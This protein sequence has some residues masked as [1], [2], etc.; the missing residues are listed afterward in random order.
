MWPTE[1]ARRIG[2]PLALLARCGLTRGIAL[3][4]RETLTLWETLTLGELT[5]DASAGPTEA[6]GPPRGRWL[7]AGRVLATV[8]SAAPLLLCHV[9]KPN[10]RQVSSDC[11]GSKRPGDTRLW[12]AKPVPDIITSNRVPDRRIHRARRVAVSTLTR[13]IL[14]PIVAALV[15]AGLILGPGTQSARADGTAADFTATA[16]LGLDGI[17]TVRQDITFSTVPAEVQQTFE[18]KQDVL[19][20]RRYV[21]DVSGFRATVD[22][23]PVEPTVEVS[24]GRLTTVRFPTNGSKQVSLEYTV[25][26]AVMST[27]EG[28]ALVWPLLQ[29]F[30]STVS[31][32]TGTVAIPVPFAFVECNAGSPSS[33]VPCTYAAAGTGDARQP[34][35]RDGPRGPGEFVQVRIGFPPGAIAAN[36]HIEQVWT[37]A[38]AFSAKPLPL[39]LALG[40]LVLGA[41]ALLALHRRA[42][43]DAGA[44]T[45]VT[46]AAEFVPVGPGQTEFRVLGNVRP[47]HV[48]T[49][50]DERVDPI[51]VTATLIDL[52]VH[53]H[54]QITELPRANEF[55]PTDWTLTRTDSDTANLHP[56][57]VALLEGV[58]GGTEGAEVKVSELPA[59]V[60]ESVAGVQDSLYDEVVAYGWFER[61]PD[62]T[63]NKW[64]QLAIGALV[65]AV[66]VTGLLAAFTSFGLIG[67]ALVALGLG[68]MFVAQEMPART[69]SGAALLAGLGVLRSDLMSHPTNQ[70]PP[71]RELSEISE[72]LPYAVVLGGHQRWLDA[73]VAADDDPDEDRFE[74]GWYHGPEGWHLHHLPDSLKNFITTVSGELFSR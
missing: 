7:V 69:K 66:A 53:G 3:A 72:L 47:G 29:G 73:I 56:F 48:G 38:R 64:T 44:G 41:A 52:A 58:A 45:E 68:L 32:F 9:R 71:G 35:F 11:A 26:G 39:A 6:L 46:K 25:A 28:T 43:V 20:D 36:E 70:L 30:D 42:G 49:V 33:E 65:G 24:E 57:E 31:Q 22:G 62:A 37:L 19:G 13:A 10:G 15:F 63:R 18:T 40:L 27:P 5:G 16:N 2:G 74:L 61:R 23:Q 4:L 17:L 1:S 54:L 12:E 60:Y 14:L 59:R 50:A 21:Y 51:D 8:R 34:T 55:A 67:L